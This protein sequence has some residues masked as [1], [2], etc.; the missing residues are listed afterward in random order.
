MRLVVLKLGESL[1]DC[2]DLRDRLRRVI[3]ERTA[4][5]ILIVVG[6]GSLNG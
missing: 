4:G 5:R 2:A 6:G 1:L 3:G